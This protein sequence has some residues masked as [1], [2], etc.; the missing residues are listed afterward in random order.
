MLCPYGASG[1]GSVGSA[2]GIVEAPYGQS[3]LAAEGYL[4]LYGRLY[5]LDSVTLRYGNVYGPRQD[6]LGEAGVIAI[7][8]GKVDSGG[9]PTVYGNG[10]QTRDYVYVGDVVAANLTAVDATVRGPVNIGTGVETSVLDLV[11][12]LREL[13][14]VDGFEPVFAPA[15]PGE[16]ARSCLDVSRARETLGWSARVSLREGLSMTLAASRTATQR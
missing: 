8:C 6:P 1:S 13:A 4:G 5:D 14:A 3:K 12:T 15:R 11:A 2:V 10:L 9:S 7:F 16:L